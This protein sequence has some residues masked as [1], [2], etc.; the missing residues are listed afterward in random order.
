VKL[1]TDV[2]KECYEEVVERRPTTFLQRKKEA[3]ENWINTIHNT[4]GA[5][6]D[7]LK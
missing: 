4:I 7:V 1:Q 2:L 5:G 3:L 6:E